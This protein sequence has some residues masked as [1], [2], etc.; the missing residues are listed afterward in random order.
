MEG[1]GTGWI[2][3]HMALGISGVSNKP[4]LDNVAEI[5]RKRAP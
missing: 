4:Y 2:A 5:C 1:P 3:E